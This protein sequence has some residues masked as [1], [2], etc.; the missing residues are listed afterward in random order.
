MV[1]GSYGYDEAKHKE[2]YQTFLKDVESKFR[3]FWV[4]PEVK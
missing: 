3:T 2:L 4:N 1:I